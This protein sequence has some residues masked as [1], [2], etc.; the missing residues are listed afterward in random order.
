MAEKYPTL[1]LAVDLAAAAEVVMAALVV[2]GEAAERSTR[3][4]WCK[5]CFV[6]FVIY[7]V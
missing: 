3:M 2:A 1:L 7:G 4:P 6:F 5:I